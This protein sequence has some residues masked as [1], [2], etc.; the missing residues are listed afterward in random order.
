MPIYYIGG[1]F[2]PNINAPFY[3]TATTNVIGSTATAGA[4]LH[5]KSAT[6]Y[7]AVTD[8]TGTDAAVITALSGISIRLQM[9]GL[10]ATI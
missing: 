8:V 1:A 2:L 4:G 3:T 7:T 9:Y 10:T 6:Q 5:G